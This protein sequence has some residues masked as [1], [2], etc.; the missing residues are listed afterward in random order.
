MWLCEHPEYVLDSTKSVPRALKPLNSEH[1]Q[2]M[3]V[4]A[5]ALGYHS[6]PASR[7]AVLNAIDLTRRIA[8]PRLLCLQP[9]APGYASKLA[10][11]RGEA[12]GGEH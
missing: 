5:N 9:L 2:R 8:V 1:D 4:L 10:S 6:R 3:K 11:P 12:W 7:S